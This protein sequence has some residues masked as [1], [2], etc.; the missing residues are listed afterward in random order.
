MGQSFWPAVGRAGATEAV[1]IPIY[2]RR[3]RGSVA[4]PRCRIEWMAQGRL[5]GW[6]RRTR[7]DCAGG[8]L[9]DLRWPRAAAIHPGRCVEGGTGRSGGTECTGSREAEL[10]LITAKLCSTQLSARG[11]GRVTASAEGWGDEVRFGAHPAASWMLNG[12][13]PDGWV[14]WLRTFAPVRTARCWQFRHRQGCTSCAGA[15][16]G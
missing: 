5:G 11:W 13:S 14:S 4:S 2:W 16:P 8:L 7:F 3:F 9:P 12:P 10:A 15:G 1:A 6:H